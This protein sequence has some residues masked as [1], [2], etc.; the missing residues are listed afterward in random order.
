MVLARFRWF[1]FVP[2]FSKYRQELLFLQVA[3]I[4]RVKR[5]QFILF[6]KRYKRYKKVCI[7]VFI[8]V[9]N[10]HILL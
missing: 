5:Y 1:E 10:K 3:F 4:V 8:K 2:H 6:I 7:P 9:F